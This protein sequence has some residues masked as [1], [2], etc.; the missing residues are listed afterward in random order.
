[1]RDVVF[2]CPHCSKH[3]V[4]DG[5]GVGRTIKC[6]DCH[7]PVKVPPP[8]FEF[9]CPWCFWELSA[10]DKLAEQIVHCPSCAQEVQIPYES[11]VQARREDFPAAEEPAALAVPPVKC[12]NCGA[13]VRQSDAKFCVACGLELRTGKKTV[14]GAPPGGKGGDDGR[15]KCPFCAEEILAAAVKC[16]HCGEFVQ[17]RPHGPTP[18]RNS[19]RLFARELGKGRF[20]FGGALE[21]VFDAAERAIHDLKYEIEAIDKAHGLLHFKV[22]TNAKSWTGREMSLLVS[23][24]GDQSCS[25]DI[26]GRRTAAGP[27]LQ[28]NDWGESAGVARSIYTKME[29]LLVHGITP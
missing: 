15:R 10:P 5:A 18:H 9:V 14:A 6:N 22:R 28:V 1:M 24:H 2:Q 19:A 7:R 26:S 3:L 21:Q 13:A 17:G 20:L 8:A 11:A 23:D 4:I 25:V 12:P 16:R 27:V 29:E